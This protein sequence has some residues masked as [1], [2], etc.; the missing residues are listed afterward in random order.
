MKVRKLKK[1]INIFLVIISMSAILTLIDSKEMSKARLYIDDTPNVSKDSQEEL[2]K[3]MFITLMDPY[4]NQAL[5]KYYGQSYQYDLFNVNVISASRPEGYRTFSFIVK[6]EVK[7]FV[8]AHNIIGI[9]H[10]TYK[11]SPSVVK[12]E[13]FEHIK[14][15]NVPSY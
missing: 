11:I 15:F 13:E 2:Y 10:I 6:I 4:I 12:L 9:D 5:T 3:D 14:S 8:G 1:S 7:P